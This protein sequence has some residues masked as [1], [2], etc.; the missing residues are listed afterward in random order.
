MA[1]IEMATVAG[2]V[3]INH[4]RR[5]PNKNNEGCVSSGD[6][7]SSTDPFFGGCGLRGSLL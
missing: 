1:F 2:I 4:T 5:E 3:H 6:L 7:Y